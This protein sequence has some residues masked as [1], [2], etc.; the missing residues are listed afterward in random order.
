VFSSLVVVLCFEF[1]FRAFFALLVCFNVLV[2]L[3]LFFFVWFY[4]ITYSSKKK[5]Q[6]NPLLVS[7]TTAGLINHFSFFMPRST[8]EF[9]N[10]KYKTQ[11]S[12]LKDT[13]LAIPLIITK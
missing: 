9:Q 11:N 12:K 13:E 8:S 7:I 2:E 10:N 3:S 6:I 4:K 1:L 5:T